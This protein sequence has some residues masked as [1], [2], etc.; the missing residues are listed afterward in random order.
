L[1]ADLTLTD[2]KE[3]LVCRHEEA[4]ERLRGLEEMVERLQ[5]EKAALKVESDSEWV[6]GA[7]RSVQEEV[8]NIEV[9]R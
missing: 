1:G 7:V 4:L 8:S 9:V 3:D 6:G 5:A 2:A